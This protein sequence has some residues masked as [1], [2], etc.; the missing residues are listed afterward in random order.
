MANPEPTLVWL[1]RDLRLHDHA[2]LELACR[3]G[4][5]VLLAFVFDTEILDALPR[6][7]RRVELI[8]CALQE[9]EAQ[10]RERGCGLIVRHGRAREWIPQL[11]AQIGATRLV[12]A[13]DDD[14]F[15]LT[16]DQAVRA[17]LPLGVQVE[18]VQDVT[19]FERRELLTGQGRPYTVFTPYKNAWLKALQAE[20]A[21]RL[22]ERTPQLQQLAPS[23]LATG[24]PSLREL[25]F[26]PTDLDARFRGGARQA[27]EQAA[28]FLHER[29]HAYAERRDFPAQKGPSYLSPALRFGLVS[30]RELA[31]AAWAR[32]DEPGAAIFLSE[33]IWRDFYH[34]VLHHHPGVVDGPLKPEY[35]AVQWEQGP[36]ADS[37]FQAWCEGRT[38][39]PLVDAAMRQLARTGYMHNRL[40]MVTASFLCKSLGIDW[41]RGEAWFAEQ[42][43]DF[44]L[45]SNNGGWQ[46]AAS[47]GCDAQPWFRIFNPVTQSEKFD[48]QGTFIRRYVPE[49]AELPEAAIHAPWAARPIELGGLR[50]GVD[51]PLPLVDHAEA[52]G[53]TLAR[54]GVLKA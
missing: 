48:A 25:G 2:A 30:V 52:R 4:A 38:G 49:L 24:L 29:L 14:P 54:Y 51:Y 45:A 7:D 35:A 21:E 46:W 47:T 23:P 50:L 53:R 20:R 9:L 27:R 44:E 40:R 31:R 39:Y 8:H 28:E 42:L 19:V 16:R 6:H 33:L 36:Q 22:A 1:R 26:E 13:H 17:A 3:S 10:L 41:R 18:S 32:H 34:Q 5:P 15:A 12:Y 37:H 43:L 11:M